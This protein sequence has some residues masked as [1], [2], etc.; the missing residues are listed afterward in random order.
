MLNAAHNGRTVY[1][2]MKAR[3][4]RPWLILPAAHIQTDRPDQ[5]VHILSCPRETHV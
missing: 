3:S 5:W 1:Q 2:G 4:R